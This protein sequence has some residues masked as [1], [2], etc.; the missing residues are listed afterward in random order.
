VSPARVLLTTDVVG[1]VWD[2]AWVLTRELVARGTHVTLLAL[3]QPSEAQTR[4]AGAVG[5]ELIVEPLRLE[6]MQNSQADILATQRL[7]NQLVD[8]LR[9]DV[10]HANQFAA[11]FAGSAPVV[12]TL[13]SDVLSWRKWTLGATD[14]PGE[15]QSYAELVSTALTRADAVVAVSRFLADETRAL[16][17]CQR[18]FDVIH[19]GWPASSTAP[20]PRSGTLLAGR[21]WDAAKNLSL[22]VD[23]LDGWSPPGPVFL[24]GDQRHPESGGAVELPSRITALGLLSRPRLDQA[25]SQATVYLSPALYDP[26]G[27]L[28]LQAALA[29]C[30]LLLSDVPSYREL[31]DGAAA[32]F[33]PN[34][35]I[36]LRRRWT[37]LLEDPTGF[38]HRAGERARDRYTAD[39]MAYQY[40][41]VYA[42]VTAPVRA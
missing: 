9:P 39:C 15:W 27:L 32:F 22:V 36:D 1:G 14:L 40:L 25:L 35:P 30:A 18:E 28:P 2:F 8:A 11:T 37:A 5:A 7:V 4:L 21:V 41:D 13:H 17:G 33:R 10:V 19:N 34:D 6:W 38:A 23:A 31:W 20:V 16:Y 26:F 42:R 12:L 3:G 24:A 29:G